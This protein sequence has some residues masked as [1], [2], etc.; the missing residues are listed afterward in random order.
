LSLLDSCE[1]EAEFVRKEVASSSGTVTFNEWRGAEV[2]QARARRAEN[3]E[4]L[5]KESKK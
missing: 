5:L 4:C 1:P 3:N 2:F